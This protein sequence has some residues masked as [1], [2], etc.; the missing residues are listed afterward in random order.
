MKG[1]GG[2][3]GGREGWGAGVVGLAGCG[4]RGHVEGRVVCRI[5][6][7]TDA[8]VMQRADDQRT[9]GRQNTTGNRM[10]LPKKT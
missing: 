4:R 7:V 6:K 3:G 1:G 2:R 8:E 10:Q 9:A 5:T